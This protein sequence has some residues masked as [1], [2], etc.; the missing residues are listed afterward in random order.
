MG[1]VCMRLCG[2]RWPN[3]FLAADDRQIAALRAAGDI[4]EVNCD[5]HENA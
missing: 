3:R 1:T 5:D 4:K 2:K